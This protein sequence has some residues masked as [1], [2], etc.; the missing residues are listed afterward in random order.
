MDRQEQLQTAI[1]RLESR[2][3]RIVQVI[4][5]A[6]FDSDENYTQAFRFDKKYGH[7]GVCILTGGHMIN[8]AYL[9]LGDE[10]WLIYVSTPSQGK[11]TFIP[12]DKG[13]ANA[14]K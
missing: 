3:Y 4:P 13:E 2:G 9:N 10:G 11:F 14:N 12:Y 5:D 6:I 8:R 1:T 7:Q